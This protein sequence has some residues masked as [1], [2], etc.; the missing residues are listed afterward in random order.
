VLLATIGSQVG[1]ALDNARLHE[2]VTTSKTWPAQVIESSHDGILA[3]DPDLTVTT[4][5][6]GAERETAE[7]LVR[8]VRERGAV[9]SVESTSL[10]AREGRRIPPSIGA[11][12][13]EFG[14]R[15][16]IVGIAR[17]LTD[18][19]RSEEERARIQRQLLHAEKLASVGQ[20]AAGVAAHQITNPLATIAG[21][22]AALHQKLFEPFFTTKGEPRGTGLGGI[23]VMRRLQAHP[24]PPEV[25]VMT[26]CAGVPTAIEAMKLGTYDDVT[27]PCKIETLDLLI[28]KAHERRRLVAENPI[29]RARLDDQEVGAGLITQSPKMLEVLKVVNRAVAGWHRRCAYEGERVATRDAE[30]TMR[31]LLGDDDVHDAETVRALARG[32]GSQCG[33]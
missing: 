9:I 26:G 5:N 1:V 32:R 21:R 16:V 22:G 12:L 17:D 7:A 24:R 13:T 19:R 29:L 4:W 18:L 6:R 3:V 8:E 2:E 31:S 30:K 10:Q 27:E 33:S 11:R 15:R 23:D 14:G 28:R 20:L 25:I